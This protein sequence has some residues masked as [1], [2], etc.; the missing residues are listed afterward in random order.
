MAQVNVWLVDW[1]GPEFWVRRWVWFFFGSALALLAV[2]AAQPES[3]WPLLI[4]LFC[5]VLLW[6]SVAERHRLRHGRPACQ[7]RQCFALLGS[8]QFAIAAIA[9][10]AIGA[11]HNGIARCRWR[12]S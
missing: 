2:A 3:L 11:L 10:S 6:L 12:Q 8:L 1:R 9:A 7:C 4:P 5:C